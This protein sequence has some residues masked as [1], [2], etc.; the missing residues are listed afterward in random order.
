MGDGMKRTMKISDHEMEV[1]M[2]ALQ[3]HIEV[4]EKE[5]KRDRFYFLNEEQN[6]IGRNAAA[7]LLE[8][9]RKSWTTIQKKIDRRDARDAMNER[10]Y[11]RLKDSG[12]YEDIL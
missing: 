4:L 10:I 1:V 7:D 8:K 5:S 12:L 6:E 11:T 9:I 3:T 2:S